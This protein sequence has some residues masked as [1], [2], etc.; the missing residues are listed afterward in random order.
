MKN[1][2]TFL[3]FTSL[4]IQMGLSIYLASLFGNWL[5]ETYPSDIYSYKKIVTLFAIF[6][7]TYS[8]IKQVIKMSND[9][10]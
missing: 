6:A 7:T 2:K 5:D 9:D 1:S 4:G 3:K 10:N 8:I